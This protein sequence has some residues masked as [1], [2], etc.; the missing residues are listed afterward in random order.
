M[1]FSRF[2]TF[3]IMCVLFLTSCKDTM[4]VPPDSETDSTDTVIETSVET[5]QESEIDEDTEYPGDDTDAKDVFIIFDTDEYKRLIS[6]IYGRPAP[7][8]ATEISNINELSFLCTLSAVRGNVG[9]IGIV[10]ATFESDGVSD[11]VY[12]ITL[13]GT[14][15]KDGQATDVQTDI[16]A[17]LGKTNDYLKAIVNTVTAQIPKNS[18][19]FITGLSLGGMVAQQVASEPEICNNYEIMNVMCI[20]SPL[21]INEK[22]NLREG[23][24]YRFED[25]FDFVPKASIYTFNLTVMSKY[26]HERISEKS[27]YMQPVYAHTFS[28]VESPVWKKYDV[29]GIKNGNS[30]LRFNADNIT[31]YDAPIINQ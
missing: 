21:I 27:D 9:P 16:L 28:Y 17:G 22:S 5:Y 18:K 1:K 30:K 24:I 31:Y 11:D 4:L 6:E 14:E 20:G 15:F 19:L 3:F 26:A 8:G 10:S 29:A 2:T 23:K 25:A 13:G 12:L 7:T